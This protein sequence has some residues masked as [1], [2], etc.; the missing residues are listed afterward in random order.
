MTAEGTTE[1]VLRL[2]ALLQRRP[3]WTG[4]E[5]A[6]ELRVTARSVRR[7]VER[8]RSLGYPVHATGGVGG[9]YQLGA[10][11]RL[12][13]L[14]LDDDEAIATAVSL[15]LASAGPIAGAGEAALRA[16]AKLDQVMP[17]RLREEVRAVHGA[18][19]TLAG[20]G[21]EIDAEV[22][23][24]LARACRDAV[25]VR[26]S[27]T[28]GPEQRTVEPVRLVTTGR[29]W[30]LM[31]WDPQ[32]DDWRTFR[33]DRMRDVAATSWRFRPREH[34]DPAA[35][36]QRAV[37]ESPYRHRARIRL[38]AD[39]AAVRDRIPPQVG[40]VEDDPGRAGWCILT[41]AAD[42]LDTIAVHVARLG[43]P[44]EVLEPPELRT[45]AADLAARLRDLSG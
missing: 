43:F 12:P 27:Y 1:R 38:H 25:R 32:R 41:A 33:L 37:A 13:P 6:A 45:A 17:P 5:L 23:V 30:Y 31:G 9:G 18:T 28:G 21:A 26:F 29:R 24:T 39:P 14:L 35:F 20:P 3:A 11:T 15:R 2:L 34:P 22:L 40:R 42:R 8:L 16:L 36:V 7:D 44:A 19:E 10:G 4:A